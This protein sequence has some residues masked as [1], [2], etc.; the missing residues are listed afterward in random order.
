MGGRGSKDDDDP[1]S[2][3]IDRFGAQIGQISFG[4]TLGFCAG[5]AVK[6]VS[7]TAAVLVGCVFILAQVTCIYQSFVS[8]EYLVDYFSLQHRRD[9]LILTGRKSRRTVL[10]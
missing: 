4:G 10:R 7:K 2:R 5:I 6:E 9:T 3:L 1:V 8:L